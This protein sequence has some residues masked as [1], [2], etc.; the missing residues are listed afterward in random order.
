MRTG[1]ICTD[2]IKGFMT[3]LLNSKGIVFDETSNIYIIETGFDIP[4]GKIAIV[5]DFNNIGSLIELMEK[6]SK[7]DEEN[8][9]T[10]VGKA[11]ERY[12]VIPL[13]QVYFFEGN[14]N[15]VFCSTINGKY[16]VKEKLYELE[17]KLPKNRFIR[18]SKSYIVN[19]G[20]VKEII[21]WFGRRF[22]LRFNDSK[23]EIEV[24][25]NYIKSFKDFLDM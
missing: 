23:N 10:I 7:I 3:D 6:L 2:N 4:T 21:P 12:E 18:V 14:G 8:S 24:S 13:K 20:T 22:L 17:S 19:I 11:D 15:Y 9:S 5:F 25:K 1:L 16:K